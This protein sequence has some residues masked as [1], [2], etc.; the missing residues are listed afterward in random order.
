MFHMGEGGGQRCQP[1]FCVRVRLA[2]AKHEMGHQSVRSLGY[3][4][5]ISQIQCEMY[6]NSMK[7]DIVPYVTLTQIFT[8]A[9]NL[10]SAV[11]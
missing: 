5:N 11:Q 4:P 9:V 2:A 10:R 3:N 8:E 6:T 7:S 1:L